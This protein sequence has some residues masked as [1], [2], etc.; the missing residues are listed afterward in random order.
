MIGGS[1]FLSN[2]KMISSVR[3]SLPLSFQM[4]PP[5]MLQTIEETR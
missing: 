5:I 2:D 3:R 4:M 1:F